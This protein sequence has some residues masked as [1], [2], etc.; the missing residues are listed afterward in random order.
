MDNQERGRARLP[1]PETFQFDLLVL[2]LKDSQVRNVV[3][4]TA[5]QGK[6]GGL[7]PAS[8]RQLA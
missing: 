5:A 2:S 7:A 8:S 4:V 1:D 3:N 6:E